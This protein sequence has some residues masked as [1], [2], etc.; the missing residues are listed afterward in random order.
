MEKNKVYN[1]LRRLADHTVPSKYRP[2]IR[3]WI[4]SSKDIPEKETAMRQIW[5][6]TKAE[7]D[8]NTRQSFHATLQKIHHTD[9]PA[10]RISLRTTYY[11]TLLFLSYP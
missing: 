4:I 6:E 7:A 10:V 8:E 1:I 2:I 5:L 3:N 11:V 9:H